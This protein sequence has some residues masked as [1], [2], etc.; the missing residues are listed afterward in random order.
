MEDLLHYPAR[1]RSSISALA[2]TL[3]INAET[4]Y[5]MLLMTAALMDLDPGDDLTLRTVLADCDMEVPA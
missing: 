3:S 4:A 1:C 5:A 2:K